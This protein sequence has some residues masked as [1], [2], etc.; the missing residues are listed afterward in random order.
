MPH[1]SSE[2][3]I[4]S[5][6]LKSRTMI[7]LRVHAVVDTVHTVYH[8]AKIHQLGAFLACGSNNTG[9]TSGL[10]NKRADDPLR[11]T[12]PSERSAARY[13]A[14]LAD[15]LRQLRPRGAT[16]AGTALAAD[17]VEVSKGLFLL[18]GDISMILLI[19]F[20]YFVTVLD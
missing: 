7:R 20:C 15:Q 10:I 19:H 4:S 8:H 17:A 5:N 16:N 18:I 3:A 14:V 2:L 13:R 1:V 11:V 6:R 12:T 9:R